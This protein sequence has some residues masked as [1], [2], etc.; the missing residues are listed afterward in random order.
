MNTSRKLLPWAGAILSF[1]LVGGGAG[2]LVL[3]CS[4]G[5]GVKGSVE[6]PER[7]DEHEG[8][9][10]E[11]F[12]KAIHPTSDPSLHISVQQLVSVE[13]FSM[14]ELRAQVAG[15]VREVQKDIGDPVKKGEILIEIRE[16]D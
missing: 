11:T 12:V 7:G 2:V 6:A 3:G 4:S 15:V 5:H 16:P 1:L 10:T 14:A 9:A 8:E 13:P